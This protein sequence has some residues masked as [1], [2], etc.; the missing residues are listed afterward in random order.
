MLFQNCEACILFT[1]LASH[2]T[3]LSTLRITTLT[4]KVRSKED[5]EY[6]HLFLILGGK[7]PCHNQ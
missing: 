3:E 7:V 5:I 1:I 4:L 6:L 2:L